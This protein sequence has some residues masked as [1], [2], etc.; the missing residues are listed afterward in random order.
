MTFDVTESGGGGATTNLLQQWTFN[1]PDETQLTALTN[2]VSG[3]GSWNVDKT[4]MTTSNNVLHVTDAAAFANVQAP[5]SGAT[6]GLYELSWTFTDI[7]LTS[8]DAGANIYQ[9]T[10]DEVPS[11]NELLDITLNYAAANGKLLLKAEDNGTLST[12]VDFGTSRLLTNIDVR[13]VF[14]LDTDTYDVFVNNNGAGE[15]LVANGFGMI[16]GELDMIRMKGAMDKIG[17]TGLVDIDH[18]TLIEIIGGGSD[19]DAVSTVLN[20]KNQPGDTAGD[21]L[22][23]PIFAGQGYTIFSNVTLTAVGASSSTGG[24]FSAYGAMG[25]FNGDDTVENGGPG[26]TDHDGWDEIQA[27]LNES[28]TFTP[29]FN[30]NLVTSLVL[31][32]VIFQEVGKL[33][34]PFINIIIGIFKKHTVEAN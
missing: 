15:A 8:P 24:V 26:G 14:D 23:D 2:T 3:G 12:I 5:L 28:I 7:D 19:P 29:T 20:L 30:T 11:Q 34:S 17:A 33:V 22:K 25:V 6:N 16:D 18:L 21:E 1:Q 9:F 13:V 10:L 4:H 32:E 27:V 31:K